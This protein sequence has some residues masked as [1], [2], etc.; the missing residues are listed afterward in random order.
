MTAEQRT[1]S[2]RALERLMEVISQRTT[3]EPRNRPAIRASL[4][5]YRRAI[6][7]EA[8]A[9]TPSLDRDA[10]AAQKYDDPGP[11][12]GECCYGNYDDAHNHGYEHGWNDAL[13]SVLARLDEGSATPE[14]PDDGRWSRGG[15]HW[16]ACW[17]QWSHDPERECVCDR[18]RQ[19]AT[20]DACPDHDED[21]PA[22]EASGFPTCSKCG[23]ILTGGSA[24]PEQGKGEPR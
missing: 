4:R 6:E 10:I 9:A 19:A 20:V 11:N 13:E 22:D 14:Q 3:I 12:T 1:E 2:S 5:A 23:A 17:E 18:L 21:G 8:A 24:T 7:R 16:L 15:W